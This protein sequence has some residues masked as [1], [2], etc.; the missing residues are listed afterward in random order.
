MIE[1]INNVND[2]K[3]L[4]LTELKKWEAKAMSEKRGKRNELLEGFA[5]KMESVYLQ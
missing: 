4:T 3:K 5:G 1:R 2:V